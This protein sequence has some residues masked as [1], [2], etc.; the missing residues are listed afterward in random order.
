MHLLR[1]PLESGG[2]RKANYP[3][4]DYLI[5]HSYHNDN[6]GQNRRRYQHAERSFTSMVAVLRPGGAP[7][8]SM[9]MSIKTFIENSEK[10][11]H[12]YQRAHQQGRYETP[13]VRLN[14]A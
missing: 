6:N 10:Q 13:L 4:Y 2:N 1:E 9:C 12:I 5:K 7:R 3:I 14:A 8:V 11:G